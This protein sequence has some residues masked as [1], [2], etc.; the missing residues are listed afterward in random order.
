MSSPADSL[1]RPATSAKRDPASETASRADKLGVWV[2][3]TP[4]ELDIWLRRPVD[5]LTTD[6]PDIALALRARLAGASPHDT[7]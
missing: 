2:P 1:V 7:W 5:Q 6:R 3:N 4:A